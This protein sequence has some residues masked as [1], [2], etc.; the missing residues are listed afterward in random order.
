MAT[1]EQDLAYLKIAAEEIQGYLLSGEIYWPLEGPGARVLAPNSRM[2]LGSLL[3]VERR[4]QAWPLSP[5]Q[6]MEANRLGHRIESARDEWRSHWELKA[7]KEFP[8]RLTLWSNYLFDMRQ[9]P[10]QVHQNYSFEVQRRVILELL[11]SEAPISAEDIQRLQEQDN[12]LDKFFKLS[13]FIWDA[14]LAKVFPPEP[15]WYLY[16]SA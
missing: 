1:V 11:K 10:K 14:A 6:Q 13:D 12:L 8:A 9:D 5:V 7:Q 4:L 15:F 2:T 16:G 3:L